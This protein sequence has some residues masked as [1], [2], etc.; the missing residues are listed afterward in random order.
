MKIDDSSLPTKKI[1][2]YSNPSKNQNFPKIR[3]VHSS[4][5]KIS[6]NNELIKNPSISSSYYKKNHVTIKTLF[7]PFEIITFEIILNTIE[8]AVFFNIKQIFLNIIY[9]KLHETT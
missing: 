7:C 9:H 1:S 8:V 3:N 4:T 6:E 5:K 2:R